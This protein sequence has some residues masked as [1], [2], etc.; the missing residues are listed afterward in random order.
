MNPAGRYSLYPFKTKTSSIMKKSCKEI[1]V[2]ALCKDTYTF[3]Y[4]GSS[5]SKLVAGNDFCPGKYKI[6]AGVLN[7]SNAYHLELREKNGNHMDSVLIW[8]STSLGDEGNKYSFA[9]D[10]S[11]SV[12]TGVTSVK[13]VKTK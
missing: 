2:T 6:Y 12:P 3:K 7:K 8:K 13:L 9:L 10:S 1:R 4:D 11:I 5:T